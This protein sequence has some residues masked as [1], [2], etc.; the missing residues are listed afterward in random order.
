MSKINPVLKHKPKPVSKTISVEEFMNT[1]PATVVETEGGVLQ[2]NSTAEWIET[3]DAT[4]DPVA[5]SLV[6]ADQLDQL[7]GDVD[8]TETAVGMESYRRI[9]TQLTEHT[10][11]PRTEGVALEN[12]K[13]TKGGKRN[14]AKE[15]RAHAT[16]IR[17]CANVALEDFTDSIDSSIGETVASYKQAYSELAQL[18][19]EVSPSEKPIAVNNKKLYEMWYMDG[20]VLEAKGFSKEM[21]GVEA[22]A[23]LI[24]GGAD[25]VVKA[26]SKT[27]NDKNRELAKDVLNTVLGKGDAPVIPK[28]GPIHLMFNTTVKFEGGRGKFE[29]KAV[30]AP[31]HAKGEWTGGDWGWILAWGLLLNPI[32]GVGAYAYRKGMGGSGKG[33]ERTATDSELNGFIEDVKR[34]GPIVERIQRDIADLS[35]AIA[36]APTEVQAAYKRA[37][38]PVIELASKTIDHIAEV[39]YGAKVLMEKLSA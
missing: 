36:T 6:V 17:G 31:K 22:L 18:K 32:A 5:D 1:I 19:G 35:K 10:G 33:H 15:I 12:F 14:L 7:A 23:D 29:K 4:L 39:T 30:P 28:H 38:A 8:A 11:L 9:F 25:T 26:M 20:K 21:Q 13:A 24:G 16:M 37:S 34:M 2:D 3:A 27:E